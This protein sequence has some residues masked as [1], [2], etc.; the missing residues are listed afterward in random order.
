MNI[1]LP[2][3][4]RILVLFSKYKVN[5]LL[6]GGYAVIAHGY[7]RTTGDMDLWIEPGNENRTR[8]IQAFS[9]YGVHPED[10][11]RLGVLELQKPQVFHIGQVPEKIDFLS[12]I[13]GVEWSEA[14]HRKKTFK[15]PEEGF[16]IY[17]IHLDDLIR[18]KITTGRLQDK[19]DV[20]NLQKVHNRKGT[21]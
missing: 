12:R 14:W 17:L 1:F 2:A 6:V 19:A 20:E 10:L 3:H 18:S 21:F 8:L 7:P 4:I 16:D 11:D 15:H 5:Y 9:E 13:A